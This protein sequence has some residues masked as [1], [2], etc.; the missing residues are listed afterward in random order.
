M[1]SYLISDCWLSLS[2]SRLLTCFVPTWNNHQQNNRMVDGPVLIVGCGVFGLSTALELAKKGKFVTLI[3]KYEPPSPWSAANDFNKII[4]CEYSDPLYARMAVEALYMWREDP[5][6]TKSLN[7]CGRVLVTPMQ[8]EG[9]IEFEMKGIQT[10]QSMGEGLKFEY[11]NGGDGI[12]ARIPQ[13]QRNKIPENQ[14][15]KYNPE[16]GLGRSADTIADVYSYLKS[17][18]NVQFVFGFSGSATGLKRYSDGEVGVVTESGFVH[19]ASTVILAL[20]ANTGSI[21]NLENQQSATGLFVTHIQLNHNE[22]AKYKD[23][24]ILFDAEMGYF[25]P[26]DP[27]TYIMKICLTGCGIKRIVPDGFNQG[28]QVSLP[29]FHNEHPEDTIPKDSIHGIYTLLDK[30]VPDLKNHKLFG[31]KICWIG[32][33]EGSHFLIDQVPKYKNLYVAT[34]DSGHGY[35]FFPNIGKYIVKMIDGTLENEIRESWKWK[36]NLDGNI[37]DPAKAKWRVSKHGTRDLKDIDFIL[38]TEIPKL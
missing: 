36:S 8:H 13:F 37:V 16:A 34:G 30:Y 14:Q 2:L 22:F 29:R 38:E 4:R 28:K 5:I 9:R 27:M 20:G 18:P 24:P 1:V 21:L 31:S 17:H 32:D 35:K 26:P 23:M 3:D 11:Y 25:F 6:F 12:A 33:R 19:S 7:E 15:V 10:L